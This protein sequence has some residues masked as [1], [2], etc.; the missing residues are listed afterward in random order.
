MGYYV[1]VTGSE[2]SSTSVVATPTL[3]SD[4]PIT[5]EVK[6]RDSGGVVAAIVVI[7]VTLIVVVVVA[8]AVTYVGLRRKRNQQM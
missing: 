3:T 7:A 5:A 4:P 1:L 2:S 6:G 8:I